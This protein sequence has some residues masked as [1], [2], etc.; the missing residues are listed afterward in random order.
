MTPRA[1]DALQLLADGLTSRAIAQRL[2]I[3]EHTVKFH[4]TGILGKLGTQGRAEAVARGIPLG[5]LL[6]WPTGSSRCSLPEKLLG[7]MRVS[8]TMVMPGE[9]GPYSTSDKDATRA[10]YAGSLP[11]TVWGEEAPI[12]TKGF[13]R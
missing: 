8:S 10:P 9:Q 7:N 11:D 4:V 12:Y 1:L 5:L 6:L 3:S 2:G 13:V